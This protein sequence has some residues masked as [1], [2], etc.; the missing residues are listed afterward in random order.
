MT[1]T[2]FPCRF[3]RPRYAVNNNHFPI[4]LEPGSSTMPGGFAEPNGW[5]ENWFPLQVNL[6]FLGMRTVQAFSG[7]AKKFIQSEAYRMMI[8]VESREWGCFC[9]FLCFVEL[10]NSTLSVLPTELS[11]R[12]CTSMWHCVFIIIYIYHILHILHIHIYYIVF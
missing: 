1:L 4:S 3:Q 11:L 6:S 2:M 5:P 7:G 9:M 8:M 10:K 12:L